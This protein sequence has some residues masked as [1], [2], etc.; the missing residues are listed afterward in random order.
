MNLSPQTTRILLVFSGLALFGYLALRPWAGGDTAS[1]WA[2]PLW[3]ISH[4]LA[5]AGFVGYAALGALRTG[6]LGRLFAGV[7]VAMLLPY[8][9]A[10]AFAL[11]ALGTV[12][13]DQA[14]TVAQAL[15]YGPLPLL[16]F[17]LGWLALGS[18]A[19]LM[20]RTFSLSTLAGRV[21]LITHT[22]AMLAWLPVFFLPPTG[23]IAHAVV[24]LIS[25]LVLAARAYPTGHTAVRPSFR[26]NTDL[27]SAR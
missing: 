1:A 21:A 27:A 16:T 20:A 13:P 17:A 22:A 19:I 9:G 14:A 4:L 3:P 18:L 23:R 2:S 8:Y 26:T 7:A 6:R 10:E 5:V 15:R 12:A 25:A 24:V 11:H